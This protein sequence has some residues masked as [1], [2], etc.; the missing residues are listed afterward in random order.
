LPQKDLNI[1]GWSQKKEAELLRFVTKNVNL[2]ERFVT[3]ESSRISTICHRRMKL[4]C[5]T[6][7]FFFLKYSPEIWNY[8]L[9]QR[10]EL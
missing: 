3:K 5:Y 2:N 7:S 1:N 10:V 6:F 8:M 4:K 9:G